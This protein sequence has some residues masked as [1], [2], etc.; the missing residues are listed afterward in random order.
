VTGRETFPKI[1]REEAKKA[2]FD[3]V[4]R[5]GSGSARHADGLLRAE[6]CEEDVQSSPSEPSKLAERKDSKWL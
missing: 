2:T 4:R 3:Y 5:P 6:T 1:K